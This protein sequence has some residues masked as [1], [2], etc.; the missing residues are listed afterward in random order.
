MD[1][2]IFVHSV[3]L[4][5]TYPSFC[6]MQSHIVQL[7]VL[8]LPLLKPLAFYYHLLTLKL[9]II[10]QISHN[11]LLWFYC[12]CHIVYTVFDYYET[13]ISKLSENDSIQIKAHMYVGKI[14]YHMTLIIWLSLTLLTGVTFNL[15]LQVIIGG[16]NETLSLLSLPLI[17]G[18]G[19]AVAYLH[20]IISLC[21]P[22][23][24]PSPA[25]CPGN[26]G[27]TSHNHQQRPSPASA[28]DR[29]ERD[30]DGRREN[31]SGKLKQ[32]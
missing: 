2:N 22:P 14:S 28:R 10:N 5:F 23:R 26:G 12:I 1:E 17:G 6:D 24:W 13:G 9:W 16:V 7:H 8:H 18:G 20:Q 3:M 30:K 15:L 21:T 32:E 25:A 19:G 31:R 29:E 4:L 27:Q 11:T